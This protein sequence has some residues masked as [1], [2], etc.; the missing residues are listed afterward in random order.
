MTMAIYGSIPQK[1]TLEEPTNENDNQEPRTA[2]S[3]YLNAAKRNTRPRRL[4][5]LP[6]TDDTRT[7]TTIPDS[8]TFT[9]NLRRLTGLMTDRVIGYEMKEIMLLE[10]DTQMASPSY[11]EHILAFSGL[12]VPLSVIPSQDDTKVRIRAASAFDEI[13]HHYKN[14]TTVG[15]ENARNLRNSPSASS[16]T[17]QKK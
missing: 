2:N 3:P 7:A 13:E 16:S 12:C 4:K 15:N 11:V 6:I 10:S 17:L 8:A 14:I 5:S 1:Q 9:H